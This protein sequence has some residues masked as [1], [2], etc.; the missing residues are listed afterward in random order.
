MGALRLASLYSASPASCLGH[1]RFAKLT[2]RDLRSAW[3]TLFWIVLEIS[4]LTHQ[5]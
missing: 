2:C 3:A 4:T 1:P 5:L